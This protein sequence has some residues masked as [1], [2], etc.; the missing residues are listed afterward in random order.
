MSSAT[1]PWSV[2]PMGWAR[3]LET[4]PGA[5]EAAPAGVVAG[6]RAGGARELA[7]SVVAAAAA[8]AAAGTR[9]GCW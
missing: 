8:A 4:V 7:R 2:A 5:E 3:C 6:E 9:G 1:H